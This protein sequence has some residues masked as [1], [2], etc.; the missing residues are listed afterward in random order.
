MSAV[1]KS[2]GLRRGLSLIVLVGLQFALLACSTPEDGTARTRVQMSER[3]AQKVLPAAMKAIGGR[4]LE[5]EHRWWSC[6]WQT[7]YYYESKG[8]F[9]APVKP[10][11]HQLAQIRRALKKKG[12]PIEPSSERSVLVRSNGVEVSFH[13]TPLPDD[14]QAWRVVLTS[15]CTG[16]SDNDLKSIRFV[17]GIPSESRLD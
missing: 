9:R 17:D 1:R 3:A 16:L 13:P 14:P 12:L 8:Y 7:S 11:Q 4:G 15:S 10:D 2:A 6:L 5:L